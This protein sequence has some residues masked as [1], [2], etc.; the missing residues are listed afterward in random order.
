MCG[1]RRYPSRAGVPCPAW[2]AIDRAWS[3]RHQAWSPIHGSSPA[4]LVEGEGGDGPADERKGLEEAAVAVARIFQSFRCAIA[5]ST[6]ARSWPMPR[7]WPGPEV[8]AFSP[9]YGTGAFVGEGGMIDVTVEGS[10]LEKCTPMCA[11]ANPGT[12][13]KCECVCL[14]TNH[15][16]SELGYKSVADYL[17]VSSTKTSQTVRLTL[18]NA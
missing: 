9:V 18:S 5:R 11:N 15:G 6:A 7:S 8:H 13:D 4:L 10:T 3:R 16:Q 1:R 12:S 17:L 14:G 2:H